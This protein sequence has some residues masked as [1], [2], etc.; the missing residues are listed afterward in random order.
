MEERKIVIRDLGVIGWE[1]ARVVQEER[2]QAV[3]AG[4][5]ET[6]FLLE[7]PPVITLGRNGGRDNL[8]ADPAALAA[9]GVQVIQASRGGDITCHYPGQL[10]AYPILRVARRPGGLKGLFHDL[11]ETVIRTVA[12]FG[13]AAGRIGGRT[14]VWVGDRKICAMGLAVRRWVSMHGLSLNVGPDLSLFSSITACGLTGARVTSLAQEAGDPDIGMDRVKDVL[15][16]EFRKTFAP[17]SLA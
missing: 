3:R 9:R 2:A 4:A 16:D 15:S 7:H 17:A 5:D 12:R 8:L 10:V 13:V 14:G 11:E 1:E 6:L